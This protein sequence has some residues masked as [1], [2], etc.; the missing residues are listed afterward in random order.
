[1]SARL[2]HVD[3]KYITCIK[4]KH[5]I[6]SSDIFSFFLKQQTKMNP[7]ETIF[8]KLN[9]P[10]N[11][12]V[13][14]E[15]GLMYGSI[16]KKAPNFDFKNCDKDI[17]LNSPYIFYLT[18]LPNQIHHNL[19]FSSRYMYLPARYLEHYRLFQPIF[20]DLHPGSF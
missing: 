11:T 12:P 8:H 14:S 7:A 4:N 9:T 3:I 1:M 6:G 17:S 2:K 10:L 15:A 13:I 18:V 5:H 19:P 16:I 20:W